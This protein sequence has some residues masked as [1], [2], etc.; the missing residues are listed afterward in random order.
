MRTGTEPMPCGI[1]R[2][3]GL[4]YRSGDR[5]KTTALRS[6]PH[7]A[8]EV[9]LEHE[10]ESLANWAIKTRKKTPKIGKAFLHR[11]QQERVQQK[12]LKIS[13]A[14]NKLN[15]PSRNIPY[16]E[17]KEHGDRKPPTKPKHVRKL[18]PR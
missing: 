14:Q 18:G 4:S 7:L 1:N 12:N 3:A 15:T 9:F 16:L 13:L 2:W 5:G 11:Q 8:D 6:R 10:F 17:K